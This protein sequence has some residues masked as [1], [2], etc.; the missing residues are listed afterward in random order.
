MLKIFDLTTEYKVNPVGMDDTQPRFSWKLDS[1]L[2]NTKQCAYQIK[3]SAQ[4]T[5]WDSGRVESEQ[6]T[7]VEYL[8]PAF[9]ARTHSP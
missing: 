4:A 1:D 8:G 6:S 7:L 9:E 3:V 2:P 5:V